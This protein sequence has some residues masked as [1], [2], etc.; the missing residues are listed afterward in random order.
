MIRVNLLPTKKRGSRRVSAEGG[1]SKGD[2][3]LMAMVV[4]WVLLAGFGYWLVSQEE[5]EMARLRAEAAAMNKKVKEIRERIDEEGLQAKQDRV[6]QLKTAI[7][8]LE[9]QKRT[10]VFVLYELANILTRGKQPDIDAERQR[11]REVEDPE[12]VLN[13]Q[14]DGTSVW[15]HKMEDRGSGLLLIEGGARDASDLSEFVKR[16]RASSRFSSVTHPKYDTVDKSR[17]KKK[18][19]LPA[20]H[21]LRFSMSVSVA[22]WD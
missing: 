7:E 16:L 10:P 4:A 21:H 22:Y 3:G 8:K 12:A 14:W 20:E 2:Y 5:E 11:K 18:S 13:P 9:A 6:A 15:L 17:T 19:R 1:V